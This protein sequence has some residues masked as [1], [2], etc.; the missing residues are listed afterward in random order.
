MIGI[1]D[2]DFTEERILACFVCCLET[3]Q[4]FIK[5]CE[6]LLSERGGYLI[7][8]FP[9]LSQNCRQASRSFDREQTL[10]AEEHVKR[11]NNW[12]P[13]HFAHCLHWK[14]QI[15]SRFAAWSVHQAK[16]SAVEEQANRHS[17]FPKQALEASLGS[18]MP[19]AVV[20]FRC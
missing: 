10:R 7:L 3:A 4:E 8:I 18:G 5:G 16:L 19:V 6:H 12:S 17:R 9:A 15:S 14:G 20:L 2:Q 1:G 13:G 11:G